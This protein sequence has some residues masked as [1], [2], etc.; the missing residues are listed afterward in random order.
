[1]LKSW[2]MASKYIVV[3]NWKMNPPTLGDAKKVFQSTRTLAEKAANA[4][5]IVAPPTIYLHPLTTLYKG[6]KVQFAAQNALE[7]AEG[8]FT[9]EISI[10][11]IQNAKAR[12][13]LVGHAERRERGETNQ[14][15]TRKVAASLKSGITPILCVGEMKREQSGAHFTFVR[16]QLKAGFSLVEPSSAAKV[17]VAYEPVWAI[18]SEE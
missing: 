13:L 7:G 6:K 2:A 8:A 5:L 9:G 1:M 4:V 3:A 14:D 10:A 17:I 12:Y 18:G 15:T 11:Q 16:D